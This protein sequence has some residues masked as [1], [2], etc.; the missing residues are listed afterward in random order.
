VRGSLESAAGDTMTTSMV[1]IFLLVYL[2]MFLGE[3][4]YNP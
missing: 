2:G 1:I 4:V 3:A